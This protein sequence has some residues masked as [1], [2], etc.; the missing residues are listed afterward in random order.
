MLTLPNLHP[1]TVHFPIA[2]LLV[3]SAAG[4][5]YLCGWQQP[6]LRTLTWWPLRLG[7]I[8]GGVA[9]LT[10]LLDQ[11][12]LPP[13]VPYRGI[14][15]W[16][17]T[18]GLAL[19]VVYGWL[20]YQQWLFAARQA[21]RSHPATV[22]ADLLDDPQARFGSILLLVGGALLVIA[23]GWNGGRLV[24]EWGVNVVIR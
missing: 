1:A 22:A 9:V 16:H 6:V 8:S 2:L 21:R 4:L 15:N 3:G 19:L 20:L 7:W 23:S 14:L 13:D 18:T 24:Y 17:V 10:G 12:G 11:S 5:L